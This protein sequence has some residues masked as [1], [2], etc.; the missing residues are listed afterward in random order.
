[1]ARRFGGRWALL[2]VTLDVAAGG[3]TLLAGH[4]GAGKTTLL[5]VLSSALRADRGTVRV[6]GKDAAGDRDGVRRQVALL[7]HHSFLYD[8]LSARENLEVAA[9][10]L[11]RGQDASGRAASLLEAV[12]LADR[13]R[14]AVATFSA[15]MRKR[16]S[17]ARVLL[18]DAPI[19]LLD[20][21]YGELD[22]A[23]ARLVDDLVEGLRRGGA[24]VMM[25][26]HQL[27]HGR[28]RSDHA[29]VLARGR[30]AWTGPAADLPAA[31]VESQ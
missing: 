11:G 22:A 20:E 13:A 31:R 12:G 14:D 10:L 28:E 19:A 24:A 6:L 3:V 26:T 15:G 1:M 4:N 7:D 30:V 25:S 8:A 23:G 27:E 18:K 2:D 21:P 9:R 29:V 5:R 17:L 16:L